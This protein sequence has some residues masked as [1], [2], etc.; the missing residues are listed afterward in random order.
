[1]SF[2]D[3]GAGDR[4]SSVRSETG[5]GRPPAV[6]LLAAALLGEI[7]ATWD[8]QWHA[9]VGPDTFFTLPHLFIYASAAIAGVTSLAVVLTA[10]AAQRA[11]RPVDHAVGGPPVRVFGGA[12][13]APAGYLVSGTGA[14]S[15]LLYGLWDLWWHTLYGFD[16]VIDS[17]PHIGLFLSNTVTMVGTVLVFAAGRAHRWGA[18]G[19]LLSL[20]LLL[21]A[22]TVTAVGLQQLSGGLVRW[23]A[24]GTAA[25]VV[26]MLVIAA[27]FAGRFGGALAVAAIVAALQAVFWWFAPWAARVYA[28]LVGL[29]V[30][31]NVRD[32]PVT[33]ALIPFCLLAVGAVIDLV[34][35]R[36][37]GGTTRARSA[38]RLAG[39]LG[40]LIVAGCAPLQAMLIYGAPWPG[41]TVFLATAATG[42]VLGVCCGMA[43]RR[44]GEMLRGVA[45]VTAEGRVA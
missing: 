17:P 34:L 21:S 13:T 11:G 44:L 20:A 4:A 29:P 39:A 19:T 32:I 28:G 15:F 1:M 7:G 33:P 5:K 31:D 30:R 24:V 2:A 26:L 43:G 35:R 37:H 3:V 12:F 14:A 36:A 27:G 9:D 42:T 45:P 40:C 22:N 41:S 23:N 10:T 8:I 16:A 18:I 6:V 25:L 38:A